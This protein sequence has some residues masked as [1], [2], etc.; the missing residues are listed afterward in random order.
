ML[1][2]T[3]SEVCDTFNRDPPLFITIIVHAPT[4]L[5]KQPL[6]GPLAC[7]LCVP[8]VF[9]MRSFCVAYVFLMCSFDAVTAGRRIVDVTHRM[10]CSRLV[11]TVSTRSCIGLAFENMT[12][13]FMNKNV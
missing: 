1:L 5:V 4:G 8:Y 12:S 7:S 3:C 2:S 9:L 10:Q 6:L 11:V 13:V